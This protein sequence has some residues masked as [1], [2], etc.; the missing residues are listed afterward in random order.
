[1][2]RTKTIDDLNLQGKRTLVRVDF[3]VPLDADGTVT[4]VTRINA[5]LPTIKELQSKG[6]K[7]I[8]ASHL[9]RPKG[10]RNS[11]M[12]LSPV[13]PLLAQ[14]LGTPVLFLEDCVGDQ[15]KSAVDTLQDG[16]VA[17]LENLRFHQ[18]ETDNDPEFAASL[19]SLADVFVSDAFGTAHRAHASTFGVPSI[20]SNK[21]SGYLIAKELEFLGEKTNTPS[22]PFVVILGGAKVSDKITVIDKLLDKADTIII[23]GAMAYTFAMANGK[24]VGDSLCEPDK[25]DL[26][27]SALAK[28]SEKGVKF[29][30]PV[31][32][33]ITNSLDFDAKQIGE[34]KIVDGDIPDGWEGVDIG[35]LTIELYQNAISGAQTILWNGPMGVFEIDDSSKGTFAIAET[36]ANSSAVSIIGGGDS[37]KA[38]NRSG[39]SENVTFMST[40]GGASLEFLEGKDLPGVSILDT[41]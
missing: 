11:S 39:H 9:G 30:L 18:G 4:D 22:R 8:L 6:A 40:G 15:V 2:A 17:L 41:I 36:V 23:G 26:A 19:A 37:V 25:V 10:E 24:K 1:M 14:K 16:Q 32:T 3:N 29:L 21:V 12:S 33:L 5:A 20:L 13:A 35:P 31:D 38:I 28:A 34:S 7:I 27:K